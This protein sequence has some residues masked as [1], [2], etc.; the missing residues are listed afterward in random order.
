VGERGSVGSAGIQESSAAHDLTA[1]NRASLKAAEYA[2]R[3]TS[4]G[5]SGGV[6]PSL[7]PYWAPK[8]HNLGPIPID[9]WAT[10][11]C[12]GFI[13]G[14]EAARA[15]G[16]RNGIEPR[17]VVDAALFVVGMGFIVGH[18]VHVLA[19]NPH[20]MDDDPFILLKV[21]AGFSSN[22]GFLGAVLGTIV[23]LKYIRKK[24]FWKYADNLMYGFPFGYIFGR[25]GCFSV[26][27]H[28]GRP[29]EIFLAVDFPAPYGPRLDLGLIEALW[30]MVVAAVF[31]TVDK[32]WKSAP[33][34][35]YMV[36]WA[37]LYAPGRF[38]LDFLR[39]TDLSNADV[40]WFGLTPAQYGS[41][42]TF[43]AGLCVLIYLLRKKKPEPVAAEEPVEE[44]TEEQV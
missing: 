11:V 3:P 29:S 41:L 43:T 26:H 28:I 30:L 44:Q 2:A 27:D 37:M 1:V 36:L 35:I 6:I 16:L 18:L 21:W 9:P 32:K 5:Y 15:R 19:Y 17:D 14:E 40:R 38:M 4:P 22:G 24:P 12:I 13:V 34:G 42:I 39:N 7:I 23:F 33:H 25:L 31:W 10:L 8:I 20:L